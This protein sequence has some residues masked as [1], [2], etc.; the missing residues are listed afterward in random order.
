MWSRA[1][2]L[3]L[4]LGAC[5]KPAETTPAPP[6]AVAQAPLPL[7]SACTHTPSGSGD[8]EIL[9]RLD[10]HGAEPQLC[11]PG[12]LF[13]FEGARIVER[14]HARIVFGD[15]GRAW[16]EFEPAAGDCVVFSAHLLSRHDHDGD[17]IDSSA[18]A[19]NTRGG[20]FRDWLA[21]R[22]GVDAHA[23]WLRCFEEPPTLRACAPV[24]AIERQ[25]FY[26]DVILRGRFEVGDGFV[27][28]KGWFTF[29][30]RLLQKSPGRRL[31]R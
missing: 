12:R 25:S 4:V 1:L 23:L 8:V 24:T 17:T 27:W 13:W 29:A 6:A 14:E 31:V 11:E 28:E 18:L 21:G 26:G 9:L 22:S 5:R 20:S 30:L 2:V 15:G 19:L 7:L 3:L 10:W 16:L